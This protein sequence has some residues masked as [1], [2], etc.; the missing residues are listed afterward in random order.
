MSVRHPL[1]NR[2]L[3]LFVQNLSGLYLSDRYREL[4]VFLISLLL[5]FFLRIKFGLF[6]GFFSPLVAFSSV[7]H[8]VPPVFLP[9]GRMFLSEEQGPSQAAD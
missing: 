1:R 7:T 5:A 6:L 4:L 3:T 8:N 9:G 2:Y